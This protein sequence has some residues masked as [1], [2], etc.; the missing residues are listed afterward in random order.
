MPPG[1]YR[2]KVAVEEA[3][4]GTA[5][6]L[7]D[8]RPERCFLFASADPNIGAGVA[9]MLSEELPGGWHTYAM[10]ARRANFR[11]ATLS[12]KLYLWKMDAIRSRMHSFEGV[13][14][15]NSGETCDDE[16]T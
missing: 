1:D 3:R 14:L 13:E 4:D 12:A 7:H 9:S 2:R 11:A 5:V 15:I 10:N 16:A 6:S 8:I